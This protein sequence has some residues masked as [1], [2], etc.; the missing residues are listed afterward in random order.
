MSQL[1]LDGASIPITAREP[2]SDLSNN[3]LRIWNFLRGVGPRTEKE[4]QNKFPDMTTVGNRL[5]EL[6]KKGYARSNPQR[7]GP[8]LWEAK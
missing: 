1:T 8:Q 2:K 6:R 7:D 3:Q 4:I 5:R